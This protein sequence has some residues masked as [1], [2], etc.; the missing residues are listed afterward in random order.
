M[1]APEDVEEYLRI[2]ER[3]DTHAAMALIRRLK[4]SGV[5]V[6]TL[7]ELVRTAQIEVGRRWFNAEWTVAQEHAATA[8]SD[9]VLNHLV[10]QPPTGASSGRVAVVSAEGEWHVLP[11]RLLV[12]RLED[13]G[14]P[15]WFPGG[16]RSGRAPLR[17]ALGA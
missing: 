1:T 11:V 14:W 10:G 7:V 8:V 5:E 3:G 2:A 17:L 9:A 16:S 4:R 13:V 15:V 12:R 6:E